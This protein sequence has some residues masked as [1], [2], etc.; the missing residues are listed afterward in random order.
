M[1]EVK[2]P[3]VQLQPF[4][5]HE[6]AYTPDEINTTLKERQKWRTTLQS[7]VILA[8]AV[9]IINVGLLAWAIYI[10]G[11]TNGLGVLFESSCDATKKAN[12]GVHPLINVL[13]LAV[14]GASNYCMQCLSAPT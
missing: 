8:C 9:L 6:R 14:L 10:R 3:N 1:H 7:F 12:V 4:I 2:Q 5:S 13:S 11:A